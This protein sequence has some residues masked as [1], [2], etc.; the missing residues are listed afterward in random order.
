[1]PVS[2]D[3]H[4]FV[5]S[6]VVKLLDSGRLQATYLLAMKDSVGICASTAVTE[7]LGLEH[8]FLV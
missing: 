5:I 4:G 1:M 2:C 8:S 7:L 6:E 3:G